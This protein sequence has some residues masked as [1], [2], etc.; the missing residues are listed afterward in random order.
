VSAL[1]VGSPALFACSNGAAPPPLPVDSGAS[2]PTTTQTSS[3]SSSGDAGPSCVP[4]PSTTD[5]GPFTYAPLGCSYTVT[6]SAVHMYMSPSLDNDAPAGPASTAMPMRVRLGL[7]GDTAAGKCG[8]PDPTTTAVFTWET[9]A[10]NTAAK[11]HFGTSASA[12]TTV[13]SGYSWTLPSNGLSNSV[14]MHEVH[15]CGLEPGTTYYY[16][17][18]GGAPGS[19]IWSAT[20][21]FTTIPSPS[22]GDGG[23]GG[24]PIT[25]GIYGDAR[26]VVTTWQL[27]NERMKSLNVAALIFT[28]DLTVSGG[29]EML[30]TTWL[31]DIWQD[32][33]NA[34]QFLTLGQ[35]LYLPVAGNHEYIGDLTVDHFS[36]DFAIPGTG[37]YA[38]AYGSYNIGIAHFVYID[39]TAISSESPGT[40]SPEGDEQVAWLNSDLAAANSDRTNHPF[41]FVYGHRGLFSTSMHA[42][43]IDVLEARTILAPIYAQYKVDAVF[44]GHDHEYERTVPIV[45]GNPVTGDPVPTADG[46]TYVI[47]AGVGANAYAVGTANVSWRATKVGFG[48]Q[49]TDGGAG[50]LGVYQTLTLDPTAKTATFTAYALTM[51]GPDPVVDTFTL[52]K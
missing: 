19:E 33:N 52:T 3:A 8:Y 51:T 34:G 44:N 41:V 20:Q 45:P 5:A 49:A 25:L 27:A 18:G 15:V 37:T 24:G 10:A 17:V 1:V 47:C 12:L 35:L 48:T 13:Q 2:T 23:S 14:Y 16:Q 9:G 31:D 40:A 30:D 6:P 46:T 4:G 43:D 28:G 32:P 26:D 29:D 39:D 21:S 50:Y 36:S 42:A 11:V 7:G 22:A 38:K